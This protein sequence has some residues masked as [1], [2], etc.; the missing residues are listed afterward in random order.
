MKGTLRG[1]ELASCREELEL[2]DSPLG[3]GDRI[4]HRDVGWGSL[5]QQM[6]WRSTNEAISKLPTSGHGVLPT[7]GPAKMGQPP[8]FSHPG[9]GCCCGLKRPRPGA[10]ADSMQGNGMDNAD[11]NPH[12][13]GI[14]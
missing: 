12:L 4:A 13:I 7:N 14:K 1:S 5:G 11:S 2:L 9:S 6:M 3:S 8:P 10:K